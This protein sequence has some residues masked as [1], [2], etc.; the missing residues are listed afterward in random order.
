MKLRRREGHPL[1][2]TEDMKEWR[3]EFEKMSLIDH[4]KKLKSLGLDEEDI[5]EFKREID[6]K[7]KNKE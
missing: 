6:A 1:E 2:D 7:R 5:E 4:E 3:R